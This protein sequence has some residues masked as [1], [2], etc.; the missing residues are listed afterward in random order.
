[1]TAYTV[2]DLA[3][4]AGGWLGACL[5]CCLAYFT[6]EGIVRFRAASRAGKTQS[7]LLS[8]SG[9]V[10]LLAIFP[11]PLAFAFGGAPATSW[12]FASLWVLKLAQNSPGFALLGRVF[13]LEAKP[14][15]GVF[16]LFLIILVPVIRRHAHD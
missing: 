2:P 15:A 14:L 11:V 1:M 12:L 13:L 4:A 6:V 8:L 10:D 9:I 3:K 7:Y 5:W 16:A